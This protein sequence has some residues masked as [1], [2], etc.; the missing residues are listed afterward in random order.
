[1][2]YTVYQLYKQFYI[3]FL[4][5]F[6][7]SHSLLNSGLWGKMGQIFQL[8]PMLIMNLPEGQ[9][10]NIAVVNADRQYV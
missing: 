6:L 10:H 1:M 3:K 2:Q 8:I 7:F 4:Y 9:F 5:T